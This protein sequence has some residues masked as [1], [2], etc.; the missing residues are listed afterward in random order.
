M[1][2][3]TVIALDGMGGD[4]APDVTVQGAVDAAGPNLRILLVGD[5]DTLAPRLDALADQSGHPFVEIVHA[6]DKIF[7]TEDGARAV[8]SKPESSVVVACQTVRDG[9]PKAP[10]RWGIPAR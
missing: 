1:T 9:R 2:R 7:S 5:R 8:R 4:H 3:E 6:P 10:C